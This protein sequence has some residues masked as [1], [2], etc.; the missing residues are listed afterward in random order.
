MR[1]HQ[2]GLRRRFLSAAAVVLLS[3]QSIPPVAAQQ[4]LTGRPEVEAFLDEVAGRHRLNRGFLASQFAALRTDPEV[5]RLMQPVAPAERSWL[6]YRASHLD[7]IRIREGRRFLS[8][9]RSSLAAAQRAFG[10]PAE[11]ITA[12][13][14][15]ETNYGRQKGDFQVLRTLA[16]LTFAFPERA[17]EF[18]P[19]LVDLFLLATEQGEQPGRYLGSFAGAMGYPQFMPTSWRT[20]GIDGDGDGRVDLINSVDDAIFSI[21]NYL[22]R[23]GWSPS[24]PVA[25][26]VRVENQQ[27]MQLRAAGDRPSLRV[28]QLLNARVK[29]ISGSLAK[30]RAVLVDLPTPGKPTEYW[31]GYP[32]FFAIMQ[33]N[34]S[35]FY[36]M[37]VFQLAASLAAN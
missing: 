20:F 30:E 16:T 34:R 23:H 37:A 2:P 33:Y 26:P 22:N 12:I 7:P 36:A 3:L 18:R 14:G 8:R 4:L 28:E 24:G 27:A 15:I 25:L 19:Q 17:D 29:P 11:I 10:V 6:S 5:F 35:F 21:A 1:F 32:N 31:L 13:L 9:H